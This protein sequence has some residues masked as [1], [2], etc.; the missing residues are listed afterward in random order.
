MVGG[1]PGSN[2]HR[3]GSR[4]FEL[5]TTQSGTVE[6]RI[7]DKISF[8]GV[9]MRPEDMPPDTHQCTPWEALPPTF[10]MPTATKCADAPAMCDAIR[11]FY[12]STAKP[13]APQDPTM[14]IQPDRGFGRGIVAC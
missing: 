7:H 3:W 8:Q 11:A 5:R 13:P 4:A 1:W 9:G 2:T 10:A 14:V 6:V 12:K